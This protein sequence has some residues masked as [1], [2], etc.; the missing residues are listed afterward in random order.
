MKCL[1]QKVAKTHFQRP[2]Q[3]RRLEPDDTDS[4]DD[5]SFRILEAEYKRKA[6]ERKEREKL[7][8][9][10]RRDQ[11]PISKRTAVSPET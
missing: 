2:S 1:Y 8:D 9:A 11:R 3:K 5:E 4:S 6:A 7:R 10:S